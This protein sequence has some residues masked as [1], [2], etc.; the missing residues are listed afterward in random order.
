MIRRMHGGPRP[1]AADGA[2]RRRLVVPAA[3][4]AALGALHFADHVI[5]GRLVVE[6]GLDPVWN[7]SG[8]PFQPEVTPFTFSLVAVSLI[9]LG[10]I[11]FTLKGPLWAGYW[12][13]AALVLGALVTQVHFLAGPN[14]ESPRVIYET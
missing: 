2:M 4:A 1:A 12:L 8:W 6:H 10:G 5:R 7:H 13:G 11:Y 9:L 3:V 14:S